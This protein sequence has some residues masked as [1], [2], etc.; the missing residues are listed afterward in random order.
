M[1]AM[2]HHP[3]FDIPLGPATDRYFGQGYKNVTHNL[4]RL[5][6]SR[7]NQVGA[8]HEAIAELCYPAAWSRKGSR[9]LVPHVSSIDTVALAASLLE[10]AV[11]H[12][13]DLGSAEAARMW[14]SHAKV[15]A[16]ARP[17]ED[18]H[19]VAVTA[20]IINVV[21]QPSG[22]LATTAMFRV[23]QLRGSMTLQH[24]PG[25]GEF[26]VLG[27]DKVSDLASTYP[28]RQLFYLSGYKT[29]DLHACD[30]AVDTT[31]QTITATCAVNT[32]TPTA[33]LVGAESAWPHSV[34]IID[35]VLGAAQLSQILLYDLDGVDR[36]SSNTLWMRKLELT[37]TPPPRP[38]TEPFP[39]TVHVRR[40]STINRSNQV[41]R[42]ADLTVHDF[43]GVTG[44]CLLAHQL[45]ESSNR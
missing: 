41:W 26:Y 22:D 15:S 31:E 37:A 18:L 12:T 43:A 21:R 28:G 27:A 1:S 30:I 6:L 25:I 29:H 33:A 45:P 35:A 14:V 3:S 32:S 39:A 36:A 20:D 10:T 9:E 34:S 40:L 24:P 8:H 13:C 17:E 7:S 23:G 11:V 38:I 42:S 44:S 2:I 16:G 5:R 4:T 19:H